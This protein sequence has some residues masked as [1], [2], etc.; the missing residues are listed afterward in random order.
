MY[1]N[2]QILAAILNKWM[3]PILDT[4]FAGRMQ[5]F[6]FFNSLENKIK[7]TGWVSGNWSI[8]K[9]LSPLIEGVSGRI[10]T[11][12]LTQYMSMLDDASIPSLAHDIVDKWL[13]AG[14]VELL[15]GKIVIERSDL[16]D[17]KRLLNANM[18]II[19]KETPY[20]VK[21]N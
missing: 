11:P 4:L 3:Q 8:M 1:S 17:L 13:S 7:S 6:G 9:E 15:E 10:I 21:E 12:V 20:Q 18:P 16:Q 14:K 19:E 5:S 2:A